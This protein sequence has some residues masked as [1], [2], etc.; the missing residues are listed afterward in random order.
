[1]EV[2]GGWGLHA[3]ILMGRDEEVGWED[4]FTGMEGRDVVDFHTEMERGLGMCW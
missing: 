3:D 1:M 2:G 4:V